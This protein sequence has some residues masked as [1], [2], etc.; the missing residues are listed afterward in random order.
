MA[1]F[2]QFLAVKQ[3]VLLGC[4]AA[5]AETKEMRGPFASADLVTR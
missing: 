1:S 4:S 2:K 5:L 3:L